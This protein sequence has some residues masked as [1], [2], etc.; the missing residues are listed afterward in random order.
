MFDAIIFVVVAVLSALAGVVL[1][2]R[3][4]RQD[5]NEVKISK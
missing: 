3:S 1:A 2:H 4:T 5:N